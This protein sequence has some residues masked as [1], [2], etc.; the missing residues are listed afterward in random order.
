MANE[1]DPD[2]AQQ[3]AENLLTRAEA[4][5]E[6]AE[7]AKCKDTLDEIDA[8]WLEWCPNSFTIE[9]RVS[10]IMAENEKLRFETLAR[11]VGRGTEMSIRWSFN[12][13][14]MEAEMVT[15]RREINR[16]DGTA[17]DSFEMEM[18]VEVADTLHAHLCNTDFDPE[19]AA[20]R[21]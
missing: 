19:S 10:D 4:E 9:N 18:H 12:H 11:R 15:V 14:E 21:A 7:Y 8:H 17:I 5:M 13:A 1:P 2:M 3:E 20:P 6:D 16:A